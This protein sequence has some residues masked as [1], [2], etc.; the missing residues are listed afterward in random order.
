MLYVPARWDPAR[1]LRAT[2]QRTPC[3][4]RLLRLLRFAARYDFRLDDEVLR[5]AE[6]AQVHKAT[7]R[8]DRW[9]DLE[10]MVGIQKRTGR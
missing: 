5:A 8:E 3:Q 1:L 4:V 6:D 10:G 2:F 9:G 7:G